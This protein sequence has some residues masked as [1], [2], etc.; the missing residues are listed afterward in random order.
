MITFPVAG[1]LCWYALKY[2]CQESPD[3]TI[4]DHA[5]TEF[6][7]G[8]EYEALGRGEQN[9]IS[10]N[11][12]TDCWYLVATTLE[13]LGYHVPAQSTWFWQSPSATW[14]SDYFC[15]VDVSE[16]G[17]GDLIFFIGEEA[18]HVGIL[19]SVPQ[20]TNQGWKGS[21]F[22]AYDEEYGIL[23]QQ[24]TCRSDEPS[25]EDSDKTFYAIY[26]P[27][28]KVLSLECLFPTVREIPVP[29]PRDP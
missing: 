2:E 25:L 20:Q 23:F 14:S 22:H 24:W 5:A 27:K 15:L 7:T 11:R 1:S 12:E 17:P 29:R 6:I 28:K 8:W 4:L 26:R 19:A 10:K 3:L 21:L 9:P 16:A 13:E 18:N